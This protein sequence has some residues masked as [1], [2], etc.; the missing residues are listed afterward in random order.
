[1][2]G[3]RNL[4]EEIKMAKTNDDGSVLETKIIVDG[5]GEAVDVEHTLHTPDCKV[6]RQVRKLAGN[7]PSR[8]FRGHR[9]ANRGKPGDWKKKNGKE[10]LIV[11]RGTDK[12][13]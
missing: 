12:I 10:V 8:K 1:M 5:D 3:Y 13:Q 11:G 4:G 6:A 9:A 7:D 2:I